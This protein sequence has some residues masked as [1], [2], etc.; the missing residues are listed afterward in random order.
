VRSSVYGEYRNTYRT[1]GPKWFVLVGLAAVIIPVLY[2]V[3]RVLWAT[4][5]PLGIEQSRMEELGL[6]GAGSILLV[7]LALPA[8]ATAWFTF[9]FAVQ[10]G[11]TMPRWLPILG[12]VIPGRKWIIG[13]LSIPIL[14]LTYANAVNLVVLSTDLAPSND[15][16]FL[17]TWSL[18][19]HVM[20]F[21]AWWAALIFVTVRFWLREG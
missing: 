13:L 6:P 12:G 19:S 10:Y 1:N 16:A 8:L 9:R 20:L 18:W 7:L 17:P 11:H 21:L 5:I 4:G 15:M 14:I 3:S 2:V